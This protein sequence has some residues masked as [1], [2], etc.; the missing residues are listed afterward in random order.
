MQAPEA[1]QLPLTLTEPFVICPKCKNGAGSGVGLIDDFLTGKPLVCQACKTET[2]AWTAFLATLS[3]PVSFLHDAA[4]LFIG[5]KTKMF[6]VDIAR[7]GVTKVVFHEHGIPEGS[8]IVRLNYTPSG[9]G[10]FPI[11]L[12]GND[13][14][15]R[16]GSSLVHL[17]GMPTDAPASVLSQATAQPPVKV[18][19][20]VTFAELGEISETA[21]AAAFAALAAADYVEMVIPATTAIE[22]SCKRLISDLK[23]PLTLDDAR[24]KDKDLLSRVLPQIAKAVQVPVL[25]NYIVGKAARLWGQRDNVAHTGRLHQP[26]ER[27]NAVPQLAAAVFAFRYCKLLRR[28]AE[29]IGLLSPG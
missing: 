16:R 12:H 8:R 22:F 20:Y 18:N 13:V 28:S 25:A 21:L 1:Q 26:Y 15:L 5:C 7:C 10:V 29:V 27:A 6:V 24:I 3:H 19:V 23:A 14:P 9:V 11:E 2:D 17:Y 4:A